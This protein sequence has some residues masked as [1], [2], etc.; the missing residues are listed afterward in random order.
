[1]SRKLSYN[2]IMGIVNQVVVLACN[3]ILP[4]QILLSYGSETNGLITSITQFLGFI[5][6][7]EMGV[8][9]VVQ[10]ALYK[11]LAEHDDAQLSRII[12]S[13]RSFFFKIGL[14]L[15]GYIVF[16]CFFYK[17]ISH[18]EFSNKYIVPLILAISITNLC[19][20]FL[21][22]T[23]QILLN[24][25]Q[26]AYVHLILNSCAVVLKTAV[27]V[28]LMRSGV[29]VQTFE[30]IAALFLA[31]KPLGMLLY[32]RKNYQ[33]NENIEI[34]EEPIKQK[35][36]GI[37]QHI[38]SFI[39]GHTD[40][41]VLTL[42]STLSFVSVYNIYYM[43]VAGVRQFINVAMTG[44]MALF[45]NLYAQRSE[46]LEAYYG[47]YEWVMHLG[48]SA[49]FT[50]T[51][52]LICPFVSVYTKGVNDINYIYPLFGLLMTSAFGIYCIRLPY[53]T[54]V[55]AAGHFKETQ[56]SA[57]IEAVINIVLSVIL[58]KRYGIYGVAIGTLAAMLYRTI[59]L[60]WYLRGA[61]LNRPFIVFVRHIVID[62]IVVGFSYAICR[63]QVHLVDNYVEWIGMAIRNA[64]VVF[65]I[66]ICVNCVLYK[67]EFLFGISFIKKHIRR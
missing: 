38:A 33:I 60:A 19:E 57:I 52:L 63:N 17:Q 39:L 55:L 12:R 26:R 28:A 67:K 41:L 18:T 64:I 35:W 36:N 46:K 6:L 32:V 20:Y 10:A 7:M 34:E 49:V 14:V 54:M 29:S 56:A 37:A 50:V 66:A 42:F 47:F 59:Y 65:S 43:I 62:L 45:G 31:I 4:R 1:M 48:V 44:V 24:A 51:A 5:T 13:A 61:I 16:L 30:F 2:T 3:F 23:N 8:G 25:D 21:A 27:G 9:A 11:P 15:T 22:V 40:V 53:N 58:V